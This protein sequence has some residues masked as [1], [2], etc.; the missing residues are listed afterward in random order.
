MD[1]RTGPIG[2]KMSI[3][4]GSRKKKGKKNQKKIKTKKS[5]KTS[6]TWNFDY[7]YFNPCL[8]KQQKFFQIYVQ[9]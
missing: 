8:K 9:H 6:I 2:A 1:S 4:T 3:K 7:F 5:K